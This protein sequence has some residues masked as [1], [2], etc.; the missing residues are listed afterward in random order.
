M[1]W[2]KRVLLTILGLILAAGA[3]AYLYSQ[4]EQYKKEQEEKEEMRVNQFLVESF[5]DIDEYAVYEYNYS[6]SQT[7]DGGSKNLFGVIDIPFTNKSATIS[8]SGTLKFGVKGEDLSAKTNDHVIII[9]VDKVSLLD[10]NI[11]LES[12][13]FDKKDNLLNKYSQEEQNQIKE[14]FSKS[15]EESIDDSI[16]DVVKEKL[17]T[18]LTTKIGQL[19]PDYTIEVKFSEES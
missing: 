18:K 8:A 19:V 4:Y 6:R 7:Y 10:N 2:I 3:G 1:K 14:Q 15:I 13:K 17:K 12:V 9:T 16:Y 5:Q 11:I